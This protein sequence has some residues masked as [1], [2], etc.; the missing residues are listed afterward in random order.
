MPPTVFH[1]PISKTISVSLTG[2][3]NWDSILPFSSCVVIKFTTFANKDSVSLNHRQAITS[4]AMFL[5]LII[6]T[7]S[8]D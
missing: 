1:A 7:L 2:L 8:L 3:R 4:A 5:D 6:C